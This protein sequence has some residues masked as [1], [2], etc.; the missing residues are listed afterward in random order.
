MAEARAVVGVLL[1][2]GAGTR[3]GGPKALLGPAFAAAGEQS[4]VSQVAGWMHAGGCHEVIVVIG[5]RS[6]DVRASLPAHSWLSIVE[7]TDWSD[8]MGASLRAG[9][10]RASA[11]DADA[12][13]VSLVDLPDVRTPVF[14][15]M[16][17]TARPSGSV[18]SVLARAAYQGRPGHPVLIGRSWWDEAAELARGDKGARELFTARQHCLVE[19]GDLASGED[20]DLPATVATHHPDM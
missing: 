16:L 15:R 3:M 6:A 4:P 10:A 1:A 19:C 20:A 13:L 2:A 7:A 14:E 17:A 18:D 8:G 5:A 9:L 12:A 11:G